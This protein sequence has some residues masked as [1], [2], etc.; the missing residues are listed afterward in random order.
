MLLYFDQDDRLIEEKYKTQT[1][2][3]D[4]GMDVVSYP[5][6]ILQQLRQGNIN[7]KEYTYQKFYKLNKLLL[8]LGENDD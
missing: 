8:S 4:G 1:L 2:L 7:V 6:Y 5:L 3:N